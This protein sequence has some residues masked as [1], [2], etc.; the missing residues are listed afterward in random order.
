MP[1]KGNPLLNNKFY[2]T[3]DEKNSGWEITA[4]TPPLKTKSVI[5][6]KMSLIRSICDSTM[7]KG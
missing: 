3:L 7:S 5:V 6:S 1:Q 4:P 2:L